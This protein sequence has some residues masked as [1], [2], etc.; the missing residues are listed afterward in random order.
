MNHVTLNESCHLSLTLLGHVTRRQ[1]RRKGQRLLPLNKQNSFWI[2]VS[3][4]KHIH[5]PWLIC[6][7][8][9]THSYEFHVK[10]WVN[11]SAMTQSHD[12][13]CQ[14]YIWRIHMSSMTMW[15]NMSAM[16]QSH[17]S[18]CQY[19]WLI[20]M[21]SMT[22]W[23]NMSAMTQRYD[24]VCQYSWLIHMSSMTMW[25][26]MSAMT[27]RHDSVCQYSLLIH[28]SSMNM[29][30]NMSAMTQRHDSVC[31]YSWPI[32][33]CIPWL[34]EWIWVPWLRAMTHCVN[35]LD[36]GTWVLGLGFGV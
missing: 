10:M 24:S 5:V 8:V 29:W 26:N 22:M 18:V 12:S 9:L 32:R 23:V 16:T 14:S 28:M 34:C 19:S 2:S 36:L 7:R 35:T 30:V 15:V 25:V 6:M 1:W 11:T 20:R 27:Q 17:D 13:V 21:S 4:Y 3:R 31:Q 33:I